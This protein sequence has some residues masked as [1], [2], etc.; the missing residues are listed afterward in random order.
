MDLFFGNKMKKRYTF[1]IVFFH[2]FLLKGSAQTDVVFT[3]NE[4][5]Y[6]ITEDL[7]LEDSVSLTIDAGVT[8][9]LDSLV[10]IKVKGDLNINGSAANPIQFL[11]FGNYKWGI[12]E[13]E[14]TSAAVYIQHSFLQDGRIKIKCK[15]VSIS[16]IDLQYNYTTIFGE[17]LLYIKG[18]ETSIEKS[19][20]SGHSSGM[21]ENLGDGILIST[22]VNPIIRAVSLFNTSDAIEFIRCS[23][24]EITNCLFENINDDA[25]DLNNC[26]SITISNNDISGVNDRAMEI[27]S[28]NFGISTFIRIKRNSI[29]NCNVGISILQGSS[30]TISNNT[31]YANNKAIRV[32]KDTPDSSLSSAE[33]SNTIFYQNAV[34][35][36]IDSSSQATINYCLS[37]TS[38]LFGENN[39]FGNPDLINEE[40]FDFHLNQGSICIDAGNKISP[41]D[42]DSTITDIGRYYYHQEDVQ[43][44]PLLTYPNPF[45][46]KVMIQLNRPSNMVDIEVFDLNGKS[47]FSESYSNFG[48]YLELNLGQLN[49]G[50]Y[51]IKLTLDNE[52]IDYIKVIKL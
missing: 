47:T 2:L 25:I 20:I 33:I 22:A 6:Y 34:D 44:D 19:R 46:E 24:G 32:I 23:N 18:A 48:F 39:L 10:N 12:I 9:Y 14:N 42:P 13:V 21:N 27:G 50:I 51:T 36:F 26:T 40:E 28:E 41:L 16:F 37:N 38:Y 45:I 8:I 31:F 4:S 49:S 43:N 15:D 11:P 1:I 30:G 29:Y 5:P 3:L 7:I 35:V 52:D 17:S